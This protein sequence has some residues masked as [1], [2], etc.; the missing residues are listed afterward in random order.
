MAHRQTANG[1]TYDVGSLA[2][3][4]VGG[5]PM[6]PELQKTIVRQLLRDRIPIKQAYGITEQGIIALWPAESGAGTVVDGCVGRPAAGIEIKVSNAAGGC[7][8]DR[9]G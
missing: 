2:T 6:R 7:D 4:V 5:S 1:H 3:V 8:N 9:R